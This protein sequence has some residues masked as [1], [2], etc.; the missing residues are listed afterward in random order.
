MVAYSFQPQFVT[1]IRVGLSPLGLGSP[2]AIA[3]GV[4]PK[5][6]TIRARG[7]KR[8]ARPGD[9]LQLYCRQRHPE[10]FKIGE[11]VCSQVGTVMLFFGRHERV[12]IPRRVFS[13]RSAIEL[14]AF[15]R[16]DGFADWQALREFWREH[17]P[18]VDDF[19][20]LLVEWEPIT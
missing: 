4:W 12:R 3:S 19:N 5:L 17:H 6:Q 11:A 8:H 9:T 20:G 18:G 10:G 14:D 1:A 16:K 15:A 13:A 7:M 2:I